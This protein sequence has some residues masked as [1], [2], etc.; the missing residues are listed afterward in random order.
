MR[1]EAQVE[2]APDSGGATHPADGDWDVGI[3]GQGNA[4]VENTVI[5]AEDALI[6]ALSSVCTGG[7][8]TGS[9]EVTRNANETNICVL[10]EG[11]DVASPTATSFD[12]QNSPGTCA[13]WGVC[14]YIPVSSIRKTC[15]IILGGCI[16]F[17]HVCVSPFI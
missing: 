16:L 5:G 13:C 9:Q 1:W 15:I 6:T 12:L 2:R 4:D 14:V 7:R 10:F 3:G 11:L 17:C 8:S